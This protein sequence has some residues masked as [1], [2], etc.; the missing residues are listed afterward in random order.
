[1]KKRIIYLVLLIILGC[2]TQ[3]LPVDVVEQGYACEY[4]YEIGFN[5]FGQYFKNE[6]MLE[7]VQ[8]IFDKVGSSYLKKMEILF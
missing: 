8:D 5:A 6:S 4:D 1:M 7:G 2:N 3:S